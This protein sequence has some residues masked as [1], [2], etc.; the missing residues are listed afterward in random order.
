MSEI[1]YILS[2]RIFLR[3]NLNS[4]QETAFKNFQLSVRRIEDLIDNFGK[5]LF[6]NFLYLDKDINI[7]C[8]KW[9]WEIRPLITRLNDIEFQFKLLLD[10]KTAEDGTFLLALNEAITNVNPNKESSLLGNEI[11]IAFKKRLG[12]PLD[13]GYLKS[14]TADT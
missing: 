10:T 4:N 2:D 3:P 14:N 1:R 8:V 7:L 6:D 5:A 12:I 13:E 11:T 9:L